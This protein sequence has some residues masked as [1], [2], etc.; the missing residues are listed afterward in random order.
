M[1]Q[2]GKNISSTFNLCFSFILKNTTI[3]FF[4]LKMSEIVSKTLPYVNRLI[5][6]V[7]ELKTENTLQS[8][9]DP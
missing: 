1:I 8:S 7:L 6:L 2:R 5:Q 3:S 9:N 4:Y